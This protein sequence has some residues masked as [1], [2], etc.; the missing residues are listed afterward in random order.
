MPTA[1]TA[2]KKYQVASSD[3]RRAGKTSVAAIVG[4][5]VLTEDQATRGTI[6]FT[7]TAGTVGTCTFPKMG[8]GQTGMRWMIYNNSTTAVTVR[9]YNSDTDDTV[10]T[11]GVAIGSSGTGKR[12]QEVIW[13]GTDFVETTS[14]FTIP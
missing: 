10:F 5:V 1:L 12:A 9:A 14:E 8:A 6:E 13:S 7:G 2:D 11:T 4:D 3:G